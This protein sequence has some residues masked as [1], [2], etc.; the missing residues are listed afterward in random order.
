MLE[1]EDTEEAEEEE[2]IEEEAADEE[3]RGYTEILPKSVEFFA[4][5]DDFD[6]HDSGRRYLYE[7]VVPLQQQRPM[8]M[9][10]YK[11]GCWYQ[12]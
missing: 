1:A 12:I 8:D 5:S 7:A 3:M 9:F 11:Q 4:V 6:R 10:E 2:E